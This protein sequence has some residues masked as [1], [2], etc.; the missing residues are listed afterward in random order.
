MEY[1]TD[2][3]LMLMKEYGR[4]IHK[5]IDFLKTIENDAQRQRNAESIVELMAFFNPQM[6][7]QE[8]YMQTLWD[9]LIVM[10]DFDIDVQSPYPRPERAT[11]KQKTMPPAYP[12]RHPKYRHLGRNLE[13]VIDKAMADPDPER[14]SGF[15]HAIAHYMKLSY[16]NWH[17]ELVHD[18]GIRQELNAITNGELEFTNTPYVRHRTMSFRDEEAYSGGK[19]MMN[20]NNNNNNRNNN[21]NNRNNN[22]NNN[23][24]NNNNNNNNNRNNN[25]NNR[26]NNNNPGGKFQKKRY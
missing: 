4:H 8:N 1:N 6:K 5:M 20:R 17:K 26:N 25:N 12:K 18:D 14:K 10:C 11:Y 9:H 23:R 19:R 15:A 24:N 7:V 16:S 21:N 2:R 3:G 22:N 13:L